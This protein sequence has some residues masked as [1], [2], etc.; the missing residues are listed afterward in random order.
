MNNIPQ[1]LR[2]FDFTWSSCALEHLESIEKGLQFII[3][4]L[5]TLKPGGIAVHTTEYNLSSNEDTLDNMGTVLFRKKDIQEL[6]RRLTLAGHEIY[7][8][9][10]P[11]SGKL[12]KYI[13]IAPYS[14]D[15]HLK[16]RLA[17]YVTT[18]IGFIIRKK[19]N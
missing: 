11:G 18:S 7:I 8:N 15:K 19:E 1:D 5:D 10:N 3:N 12:D 4:S 13:D 9:Y 14:Q 2:G 6:V 16:L 17:N